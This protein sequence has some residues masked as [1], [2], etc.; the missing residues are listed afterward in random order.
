MKNDHLHLLA[1][2]ALFDGVA[3]ENIACMLTCLDAQSR[4][5]K[6][7]DTVFHQGTPTTQIAVVLEGRL[8]IQSDDYWGNRSIIA[9]LSPGELFGEAYIAPTSGPMLA[10]VVCITDSVVA[11]FAARKVLTVCSNACPF[12]ALVVQNLFNVLA[13]KNRGLMQKLGLLATRTTR[14]KLTRYLTAE[15]LRA[16]SASF[17]IPFNRQ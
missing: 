10:D 1:G 12:H 14:A 17:T 16:G 6:K 5:Y 15:S 9:E 7:G 11:L 2:T 8:H 13:G 3:P 4:I